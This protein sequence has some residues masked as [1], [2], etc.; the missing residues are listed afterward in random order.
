MCIRDR[1]TAGNQPPV[2]TFSAP[3]TVQAG[4]VASLDAR[5]SS[6][7]EGA[8]LSFSWDFGDGSRGGAAQIAHLYSDAG[9]YSVRLRVTDALG[10]ASELTREITVTAPAAA[11]RQV[12]VTGLVKGLDGQAL[13]GALVSAQGS[14][15]GATSDVQGRVSLTIGVGVDVPLRISRSGYADQTRVLNLPAT[16]GADG[17]FEVALMQRAAVQTLPDA[18]AGGALTGT[19]GARITLPPTSLV[20]AGGAAVTGA[21]D[22]T[23]TPVDINSAALPA[24]PG[25]F[26]GLN[27]DGS[28]TPIVSFGTVEFTLSQGGR[29]LQLKPGARATLELPLYASQDLDRSALVAGGSLPLWSLDERSGQWVNEGSGTLVAATASPT[30]LAMRAEVGH[31]SW[32]NADRGYR[33]YRPKPRCINDVP[34]QYDSIFEQATI[35]K[36]LAE[37]D[38]PIPAQGS[39]A[40]RALAL[41][42]PRFPFPAVR[43]EGELPI[44]SGATFDIPPD[45]DVVL[46]GSALNGT[47]QGRVVVR[48][49]E[50]AVGDVTVPLRPV[51]QGGASELITLPFDQVRAAAPLRLD[52]YRFVATAGQGVEVSAVQADGSALAGT[53]RVRDPAG[54]LLFSYPFGQTAAVLPFQAGAAGEYGIEIEPNISVAA[55]YRLQV[56]SRAAP[57]RVPASALTL[58]GSPGVPKLAANEA[59]AA[60]AVWTEPLSGRLAL[61][62]S[63]FVPA[64][65]AWSSAQTVAD[66]TGLDPLVPLQVGIDAAGNASVAWDQAALPR[67]LRFTAAGQTWGVVQTVGTA[68]CPGGLAQRLA[69]GTQGAVTLLWQRGGATP[70]LCARHQPAAGVW[71]AERFIDTPA[72]ATA[73]G[74]ALA[75]G[76]DG[77]AAA[78]WVLGASAGLAGA[79][80]DPSSDS[81]GAPATVASGAVFGP[82]LALS[83][84]GEALA[85]WQVAGFVDA[86]RWPAGASAWQ[87]ARRLGDSAGAVAPHVVWQG[88]TSFQVLWQSF[89]QGPRSVGLDAATG[90]W[91]SA[92]TFA[93]GRLGGLVG[94]AADA[95]GNVV[96]VN[97]S[98]RLTGSGTE[99][100]WSR[101]SPGGAWVDSAAVLTQRPLPPEAG[102]YPSVASTALG[103][104]SVFVVWRETPGPDVPQF[105]VV[106]SRF[107]VQR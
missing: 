106:A 59:G 49:A 71:G 75:A 72:P 11:A 16:T 92:Q 42:A 47:W 90:Q 46:S 41:A 31:L 24:F 63:R 93:A 32:W 67:L 34:G 101:L 73:T 4:S 9:R 48:G 105:S 27:G 99:L 7:P 38:K 15:A 13:A 82:S 77:R 74:L 89:N 81:W 61:R 62:A 60:V 44:G 88:G 19:D 39:G 56:A 55:A 78:V 65:G 104:G 26:D 29:A 25:R 45:Y 85:T 66:V 94:A 2:S 58:P 95:A 23:M 22:V 64:S 43:I 98:N 53:L 68:A 107:S 37:M 100:V 57:D 84:D 18:A 86:A 83:T 40:E 80:F 33:P 8:A 3:L 69:V 103:G 70:G 102:S 17:Y 10:A 50:G 20:D 6:D 35:C 51:A 30:G 21:V 54:A 91:G 97:W 1:L 36:M 28:R 96:A 79:R 52:R 5:A 14:T 87:A 76:A 12:Q